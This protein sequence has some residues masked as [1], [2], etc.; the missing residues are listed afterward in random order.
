MGVMLSDTDSLIP[1]AVTDGHGGMLLLLL[2]ILRMAL[3]VR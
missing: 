3:M 2:R 1:A